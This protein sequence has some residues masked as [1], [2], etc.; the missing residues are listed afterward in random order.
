MPR[1]SA[2]STRPSNSNKAKHRARAP[3][4]GC[5]AGTTPARRPPPAPRR[6]IPTTTAP[7]RTAVRAHRRVPT[8]HRCCLAVVL[9]STVR[10]AAPARRRRLRL[11]RGRPRH[12]GPSAP[13][14]LVAAPTHRALQV[15]LVAEANRL[16]ALA[17]AGAKK[18]ARATKAA[19]S[20]ARFPQ[21]IEYEL[22]HADTIILLGLTNAI[23]S[24]PSPSPV[25]LNRTPR[26]RP[27]AWTAAS[28]TWATSNACECDPHTDADAP[29]LT[30]P[31]AHRY[32]LNK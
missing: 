18:Q 20:G 23:R 28:P 31:R 6:A 2:A 16:L 8:A 5:R 29:P 10:T 14:A 1:P 19:R 30:S 32:A 13:P 3:S 26:S 17:E 25:L 22:I 27:A 15:S 12:G 11:P 9:P 4:R 7:A 21:G 24:V